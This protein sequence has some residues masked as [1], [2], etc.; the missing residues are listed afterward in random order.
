M[1]KPFRANETENTEAGH[2][3]V[4]SLKSYRKP[5]LTKL[6]AMQK[7]TL[8]GSRGTGDSSNTIAEKNPAGW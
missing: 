6:G 7:Y 3:R 8:G 1:Q 2:K 5:E 4:P